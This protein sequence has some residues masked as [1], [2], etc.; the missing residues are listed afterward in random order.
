MHSGSFHTLQLHHIRDEMS[1]LRGSCDAHCEL[2]HSIKQD[3]RGMFASYPFPGVA[4][5]LYPAAAVLCNTPAAFRAPRQ[6]APAALVLHACLLA[7]TIKHTCVLK[8]A[9]VS[10]L[11]MLLVPP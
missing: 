6:L 5:E 11:Y 10:Q 4:C 3:A 8:S 1:S 9:A 2:L 7:D